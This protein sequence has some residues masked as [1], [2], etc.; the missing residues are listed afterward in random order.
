MYPFSSF[1]TSLNLVETIDAVGQRKWFINKKS[2]IVI[3]FPV[4]FTQSKLIDIDR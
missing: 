1:I 3:L 4:Y 2:I